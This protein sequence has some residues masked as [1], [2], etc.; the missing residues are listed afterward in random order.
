M[1]TNKPATVIYCETGVTCSEWS[2]SRPLVTAVGQVSGQILFF[3]FE[4]KNCE[5]ILTLPAAE[6]SSPIS[7]LAFNKKK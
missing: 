1:Q 4:N 2:V 3:N 5:P 6:K 7:C